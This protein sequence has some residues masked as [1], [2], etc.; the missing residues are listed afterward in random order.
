MPRV[1]AVSD[2]ERFR[3]L[4]DATHQFPGPYRLSVITVTDEATVAA[5]RTAIAAEGFAL[6][7]A[8]DWTTQPSRAGRY[9]SHRIS[10]HCESSADVVNVYRAVRAVAGVVAVM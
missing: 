8:G 4:L 5:L 10:L 9:T 1:S 7:A 6:P 3:V 2:D